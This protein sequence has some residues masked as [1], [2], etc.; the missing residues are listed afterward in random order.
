MVDIMELLSSRRSIRKFKNLL[1]PD[2]ILSMLLEA[3]RLAPS[4]ANSQPWK[5]IVVKDPEIKKHL[6]IASYNQQVVIDAPI[7]IVVLGVI[8]PRKSVPDRTAEL[9]E[10]GCID[11]DVKEAADHVLDDWSLNELKVDAALNS[12]IAAAQI[13]LAAHGLGLG[14][15]WVKLVNDQEVLKVLNTP[16]QFYHTGILAIGY[17]DQKPSA[18]PRLPLDSM[19]YYDKFGNTSITQ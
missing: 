7:L 10:A 6:S 19:L 12:A 15:C 18:R 3:G 1:V 11:E 5:F 4:R 17:P 2:D 8:D 9:V 13:M 14:C 16:E